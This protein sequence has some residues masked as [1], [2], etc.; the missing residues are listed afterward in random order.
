M[1]LQSSCGCNILHEVVERRSPSCSSTCNDHVQHHR[2]HEQQHLQRQA[3]R[4][5]RLGHWPHG[6]CLHFLRSHDALSSGHRDG[7][8]RSTSPG[9]CSCSSASRRFDRCPSCPSS[10]TTTSTRCAR[11]RL[12][13][14]PH[15]PLQQMRERGR[16]SPANVKS[17]WPGPI[18][19]RPCL[20]WA[21]PPPAPCPYMRLHNCPHKRPHARPHTWPGAFAHMSARFHPRYAGGLSGSYIGPDR[22]LLRPPGPPVVGRTAANAGSG[23]PAVR[24]TAWPAASSKDCHSV[25]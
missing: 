20:H 5:H 14:W 13:H 18:P 16:A 21:A 4:A 22:R 25:C 19:Q 17:G 8:L 3:R 24:S 1:A 10:S 11:W 7:T 12:L 9:R 23:G 15:R 2:R 6:V